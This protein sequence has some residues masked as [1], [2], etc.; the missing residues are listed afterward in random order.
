[1]PQDAAVSARK[2]NSRRGMLGQG[3][4]SPALGIRDPR[5]R[6]GGAALGTPFVLRDGAGLKF[7]EDGSMGLDD[8]TVA[9][10]DLIERRLATLNATL[11]LW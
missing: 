4:P 5:L 7:N 9:R 2:P 1:M 10:L 8:K 11:K 3:R 6:R